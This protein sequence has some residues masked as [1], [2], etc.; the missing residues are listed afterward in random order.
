MTAGIKKALTKGPQSRPSS[1]RKIRLYRT[2]GRQ[3]FRKA[4][5]STESDVSSSETM[6]D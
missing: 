3:C 4:G 5:R 2:E 1:K 6:K